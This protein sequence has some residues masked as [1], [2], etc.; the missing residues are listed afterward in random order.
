[1]AGHVIDPADP[2]G[3]PLPEVL[4]DGF[5]GSQVDVLEPILASVR[6][7]HADPTPEPLVAPLQAHPASRR[8]LAAPVPS[9]PAGPL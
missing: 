8:R 1:M 6:D 7:S 4:T 5:C 3:G 9:S 2:H